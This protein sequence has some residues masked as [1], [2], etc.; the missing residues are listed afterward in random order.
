M[1]PE[2]LK[3]NVYSTKNDIWSIGIMVYELLHG[4]TPWDCKTETELIDKM[5]KIP[6]RFKTGVNI[7]DNIKDFIKKCLEVNEAKRMGLKE[8]REWSHSMAHPRSHSVAEKHVPVLEKRYSENVPPVPL[9]NKRSSE[10]EQFQ[11]KPLGDVTNRQ[12]AGVEKARS[13]S[14]VL[15]K[16]SQ[17]SKK[18]PS[19]VNKENFNSMKNAQPLSKAIID[20]NNTLVLVEINKFRLMFKI[21]EK[22][23]KMAPEEKTLHSVLG[24]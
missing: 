22:L 18:D 6:V 8:L 21:Y 14:N 2:A 4:E 17:D 1:S 5:T 12:S 7:S 20:K 13:Y 11:S 3:K 23:K 24:S 15:T 9:L 19:G 16:H 10:N